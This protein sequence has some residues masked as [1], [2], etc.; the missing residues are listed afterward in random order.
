[1]TS[2]T[3]ILGGESKSEPTASCNDALHA[4]WNYP[5]KKECSYPSFFFLR[6]NIETI[7]TT[8][9]GC[10]SS[11]S[12]LCHAFKKFE[13]AVADLVRGLLCKL[14][15]KAWK[16]AWQ[17]NERILILKYSSS[18]RIIMINSSYLC[19]ANCFYYFSIFFE[20]CIMKTACLVI[21]WIIVREHCSPSW[22]F[23]LKIHCLEYLRFTG[24]SP[25]QYDKTFFLWQGT[26]SFESWKW[27]INCRA[28]SSAW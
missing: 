7:L 3:G 1:M 17:R 24:G 15:L 14:P 4:A 2:D 23:F 18:E 26:W 6:M 27:I 9:V 21:M 10:C 20:C 28:H 22:Q 16:H 12:W 25:S 5:R 8:I 19:A 13:W 11:V